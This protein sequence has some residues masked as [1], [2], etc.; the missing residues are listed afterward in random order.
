VFLLWLSAQLIPICRYVIYKNGQKIGLK[1]ALF[2]L[3]FYSFLVSKPQH[4]VVKVY[5]FPSEPHFVIRITV[6]TCLEEIKMMPPETIRFL[7]GTIN[8]L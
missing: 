4:I 7:G 5:F 3:D 8:F 6:S 2:V 1:F